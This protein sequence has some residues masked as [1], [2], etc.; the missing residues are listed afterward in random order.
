LDAVPVSLAIPG[1]PD[2]V[3]KFGD[4]SPQMTP[5]AAFNPASALGLNSPRQ[6]LGRPA[7]AGPAPAFG[8]DARGFGQAVGLSEV[9]EVAQGVAGVAAVR[10]TPYGRG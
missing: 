2:A 1:K 9:V 8:F 4:A 7:C 3:A 5:P 10:V 6:V